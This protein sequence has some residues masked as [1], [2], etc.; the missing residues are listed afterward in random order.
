[1]S[2]KILSILI[3]FIVFNF[4]RSYPLFRFDLLSRKFD[5]KNYEKLYNGSQWVDPL[6]KKPVGDDIVYTFAGA[7]YI[8]GENPIMINSEHPPLGKNL[9]GLSAIYL[10]N[11]YIFSLLSG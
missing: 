4:I 7:K 1:M 5:L 3:F 10:K 8:T 11:E 6:S 9:I 2:K